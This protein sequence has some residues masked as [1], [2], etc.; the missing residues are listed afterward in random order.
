MR[1]RTSI[2]ALGLAVSAAAAGAVGLSKSV[3]TLKTRTKPLVDPLLELPDDVESS[4]LTTPDGARIHLIERGDG[5]PILLVHGITISSEVWAPQMHLLADHYRVVAM[6][7]RGHGRSTVGEEGVGRRVAASDIANVIKSLNLEGLVIVGHSMGGMILME[8][9]GR[10]S[11]LLSERVAGLVFMDTAASGVVPAPFVPVARAAGKVLAGRV[12]AGHPPLRFLNGDSDFAW[13]VARL[14]FGSAPSG[15]AVA[16][17]RELQAGAAPSA[18]V[19]SGVD[20]I[21]HDGRWALAATTTPSLVLVGSRDVLTPVRQA[22]KI[23]RLLANSRLEV[24]AGAGHQ[25]MQ[26][27]P[28]EVSRLIDEFASSLAETNAAGS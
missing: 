5:R 13:L 10:Y 21:D 26:E 2:V 23:A 25:L 17:L 11:K 6:D 8:F 28:R 24:L 7:L 3:E 22:R 15:R 1:A 12:E 4:E 16:Q 14:G 20:L 19:G 18:V 9:A 27:R